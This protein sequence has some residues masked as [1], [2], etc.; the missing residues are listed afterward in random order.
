[1]TKVY[2]RKINGLLDS[3]ELEMK[4]VERYINE[5]VPTRWRDEV[6]KYFVN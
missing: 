6:K 5:N 4:D 2:V 1:M 3:G